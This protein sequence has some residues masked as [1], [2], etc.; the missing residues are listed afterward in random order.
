[1]KYLAL[2]RTIALLHQYQREVKT[3]QHA[4]Q[5]IDYIE[6]TL[7]DIAVANRLAHDVLGR[8]LDEM[9]PQ[10]RRLLL[11]LEKMVGEICAKRKVECGDIA[12]TRRQIREYTGWGNSQLHV[13]LSRLVDLEYVIAH[14]ADHGT[15]L[16]Y[17]LVYNG[18][19]KDGKR[20]LSG[21]LDTEKLRLT[22]GYDEKH[23]GQ[24]VKHPAPIRPVSGPHP[25]AIRPTENN[26]SPSEKSPGATNAPENA[27]QD[28]APLAVAS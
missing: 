2:I 7:D 26:A 16:V 15:G 3:T 19:G 11:L 20:F 21:L 17:E 22:H 25:G 1:M 8:C 5:T 14:R 24:N 12:L 6:V 13:H 4:G 10:T 23:P 28:A 18:A 27:H 9:P